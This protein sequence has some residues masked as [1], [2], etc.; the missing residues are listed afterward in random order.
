MEKISNEILA[1]LK[2]TLIG[3]KVKIRGIAGDCSFIGYN[4]WLPS[5]DLQITIGRMPIPNIKITE[6]K[7]LN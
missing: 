4:E 5:W 7:V 2:E 3:K 1:Q 6:I